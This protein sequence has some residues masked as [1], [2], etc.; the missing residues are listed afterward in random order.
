MKTFFIN[1]KHK[2]III[3]IN[4]NNIF[5]SQLRLQKILSINDISD[6]DKYL[7]SSYLTNNNIFIQFINYCLI[8]FN[9]SLISGY[10]IFLY[11]ISDCLII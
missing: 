3:N 8:I 10:D 6:T 7:I 4:I 5:L 11:S 1:N 9:N 2:K